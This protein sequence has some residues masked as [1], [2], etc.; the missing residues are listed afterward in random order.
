MNNN[1]NYYT[2]ENGNLHRDIPLGT[3]PSDAYVRTNIK[4]RSEI[5]KVQNNIDNVNALLSDISAQLEHSDE[6]ILQTIDT[7]ITDVNERMLAQSQTINNRI[8]GEVTDINDTILD[9]K[10]AL[11]ARIDTIVATSTASEGNTELT[12]I[13]VDFK[14]RVYQ[15]AGTAVREQT[16]ALDEEIIQLQEKIG[17]NHT[18]KLRW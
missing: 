18:A 5:D 16:E 10:D 3:A 12:D 8:D 1:Y 11:S 2:D 13:R 17:G 14:G 7:Q 4:L 9:E 6:N 15:T